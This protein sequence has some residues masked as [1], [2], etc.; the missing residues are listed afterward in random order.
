MTRRSLQD[1]DA[2]PAQHLNA[3][4]HHAG[5]VDSGCE[6]HSPDESLDSVANTL[7]FFAANADQLSAD[8]RGSRCLACVCVDAI[9]SFSSFDSSV[10]YNIAGQDYAA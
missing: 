5:V 10:D 8:Y 1:G 3:A 4:V 6:R 9:H 2:S 7:G